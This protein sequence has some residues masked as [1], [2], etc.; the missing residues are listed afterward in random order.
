MSDA[1]TVVTSLLGGAV[2]GL[3]AAVAMNVPMSRQPDGWTPAVIATAV[4]TRTTPETVS[5]EQAAVVHHVTGVVAGLLYGILMFAMIG[6]A[7]S[8]RWSGV[9]MI[10]HVF[11]VIAV[12]LFIYG[13]FSH[14]VFPRVG[15]T[16]YEERATAIRGQ[17]LRSSLV[18]AV[19]LT[20]V[21]PPAIGFVATVVGTA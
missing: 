2:A 12:T 20:I 1:V 3:V 4:L 13:F 15:G 8:L 18:F 16:V 21:G 19:A 14:V 10:A 6:V 11:A 7:P 5:V 17:W 9:P